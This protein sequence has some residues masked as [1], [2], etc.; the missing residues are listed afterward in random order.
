MLDSAD[1]TVGGTTTGAGNL[2][3]ANFSGV[4]VSGS[5]ATG[6]LVAGNFIGT[7]G[8][9]AY[10]LGNSFDGVDIDGASDNTIGGLVAAARNLISGNDVGVLITGT[11]AI[12]NLVLGNYIGTDVTGLLVLGNENEG[13]R[14][15]GA[16]ANTIGGTSP[17]ATNVISGNGWGVTI[18]DPT[19]IDNVVQGN[20]IGT[21]ADGLT[22][23]GNEVEGVLVTNGASNNLIGGLGTGQGNTIAFNI[24]DGVEINGLKSL[25][26]GILSNRIFANGGLGIDLVDGGNH[27]Q[28]APVLTSVTITSTGV[29]VQGTLS[30][31]PNTSY[32]IQFF[33]DAPGSS[34]IDGE[35]LGAATVVTNGSG[36]VSFPSPSRPTS[37]RARASGQPRPTRPITRRSSRMK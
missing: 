13:V 22:P 15:E 2:I 16:S 30:S 25:G 21:G 34:S 1:N 23:L 33:L 14:I 4:L 28:N 29:T 32:L 37:H 18:T 27:L 5:A 11:G 7:D 3:S 36:T 9:G 17:A 26:N 8:T 12:D 31:Q 24:G 10:V 6:N 19:A 35:L 20:L